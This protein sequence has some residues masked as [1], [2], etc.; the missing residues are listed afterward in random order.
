MGGMQRSD[1][2]FPSDGQECAAWL[3]RPV[4]QGAPPPVVVLGHG[5][6]GVKEMRLDAFAE[7]F[8]DAGYACLVFDY[9]HFGASDGEP[10]QLLDISRE[11]A[12]WA[13]A[14]AFARSVDGVDG[15]R[16]VLWGSSFGGGLV[17]DAA[18][19]DGDVAAVISQ[20][21]FTDGFA[22]ARAGGLR[23]TAK[24][25]VRALRDLA[26]SARGA[27]PV[28]VPFAGAP[29]SAALMAAPDC[30]P[31]Y[32][33]IASSAPRFRNEVCARFALAVTR[34]FP[35]RRAAELRCPVFF[36]L[37]RDDT[38]APAR[39]SRRH[40]Q[41]APRAEIR[42]YPCGHFDIYVGEPFERAAADYVDFLHRRV[43][44]G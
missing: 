38:V 39:A 29:G 18:A 33:A 16:I 25:A 41:R 2:R 30:L 24:V 31:G 5:L 8:C 14:I 7:R 23:S 11:L 22:S 17:I 12:D 21:P 44:V 43:P 13:A 26:S 3:Y 40:A 27:S 4:R 19:A 34:Y 10:R 9:R 36:A 15:T 32:L 42:E 37:C 1:V 35:G 28:M 20:C 6:G